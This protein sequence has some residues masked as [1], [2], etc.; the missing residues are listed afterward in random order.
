M[1][2]PD[3]RGHG[4]SDWR[5][6]YRIDAFAGDIADLIERC[7]LA[8][9][10]GVGHSLGGAIGIA[11]DAHR[12]GLLAGLVVVD[13]GPEL[14]AALLEQIASNHE[15]RPS[16]F[17]DPQSAV[18]SL[19]ATNP[20]ATDDALEHRVRHGLVETEAGEWTWRH[21]PA[22]FR[23][24]P[25]DPSDL[26]DLWKRTSS[27]ALVVRGEHS[28]YLD[29]PLSERMAAARQ[30]VELAVVTDAGH[31]VPTDNPDAFGAV[32]AQWVQNVALHRT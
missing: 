2:A 29:E 6:D 21:D 3:L 20:F 14:P 5:D 10:I 19:R 16:T 18:A 11:L 23:P 30:N 7:G 17:T 24:G 22:L 13:I 25:P 32:V 4:T 31:N 15:Q 12:P 8:P 1:V 28:P 9:A 27:P 26:W